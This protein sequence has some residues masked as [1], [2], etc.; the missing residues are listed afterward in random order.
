MNDTITPIQSASLNGIAGN[1]N[2]PSNLC[3]IQWNAFE[4]NDLINLITEWFG[5]TLLW[6]WADTGDT[7]ACYSCCEVQKPEF[8]MPVEMYYE[9]F[10]TIEHKLHALTTSTTLK[11]RRQLV[12]LRPHP[13][14][15]RQ[16]CFRK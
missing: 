6:L 1:I 15:H 16:S 5:K 8:M 2:P 9:C 3:A 10:H 13:R 11:I 4:Q 14:H 7:S 12:V